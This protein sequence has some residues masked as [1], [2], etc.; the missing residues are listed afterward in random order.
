MGNLDRTAAIALDAG[1][2]TVHEDLAGAG[3]GL[4]REGGEAVQVRPDLLGV[5]E[6]GFTP[7]AGS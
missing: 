2:L 4:D 5:E 7:K 3:V 1:V 6:F